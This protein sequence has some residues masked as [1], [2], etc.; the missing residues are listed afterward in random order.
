MAHLNVTYCDQADCD[1]PLLHRPRKRHADDERTTIRLRVDSDGSYYVHPAVDS[2]PVCVPEEG[3]KAKLSEQ[4]ISRVQRIDWLQGRIRT[5][6]LRIGSEL[7]DIAR[8]VDAIDTACQ[9]VLRI[10]AEIK[11]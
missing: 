10:V 5:A 3:K 6:R 9:D 7:L 8:A 4:L 1:C 11:E 2:L